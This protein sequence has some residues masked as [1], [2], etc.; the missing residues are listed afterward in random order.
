M[1]FVRLSVSPTLEVEVSPVTLI[2]RQSR[3]S[4]G[5]LSLFRFLFVRTY[6]QLPSSEHVELEIRNSIII[7]KHRIKIPK[8]FALCCFHFSFYECCVISSLY[9]FSECGRRGKGIE[10]GGK[11]NSF[12]IS[13][14]CPT[15]GIW[16]VG[17]GSSLEGEVK[18]Q[19]F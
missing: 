6:G 3:M 9:L 17:G 2:P 18:E 5:I 19:M 16:G 7:Y 11:D 10:I 13:A 15:V 12:N 4:C 1:L 8:V 14:S